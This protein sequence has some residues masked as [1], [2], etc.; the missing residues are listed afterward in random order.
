MDSPLD[1][2]PTATVTRDR[3]HPYHLKF[4]PTAA[5]HRGRTLRSQPDRAAIEEILSWDRRGFVSNRSAGDRRRTSTTIDARSRPDHGAIVAKIA[6]EIVAK[7]E[8]KLKP[9]SRRFVAELKPRSMPTES[10]PRR[11]Q[12]A[13]TIASITYDFGPN[14]LFK[15]MYFPSLFFNF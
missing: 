3:D 1:R 12:T 10:L 11:H 9:N 7:I 6:A 14:S 4:N 8:A 13:S 2:D 15:S 5:K